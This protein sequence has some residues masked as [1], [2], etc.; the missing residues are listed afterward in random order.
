[1]ARA[2]LAQSFS[3]SL[4]ARKPEAILICR[5]SLTTAKRSNSAADFSAVCALT[6]LEA[7]F[8]QNVWQSGAQNSMPKYGGVSGAYQG[9][10]YRSI[11][12]VRGKRLRIRDHLALER[13]GFSDF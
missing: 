8:R 9:G 12:G 7:A 1:M 11:F 10:T 3:E 4:K 5:P 6:Q 13:N 2:D